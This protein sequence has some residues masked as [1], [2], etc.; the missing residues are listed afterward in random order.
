MPAPQPLTRAMRAVQYIL[1]PIAAPAWIA[2]RIYRRATRTDWEFKTFWSGTI[3][4]LGIFLAGSVLVLSHSPF[5]RIIG[6]YML[7][8]MELLAL[9]IAAAV[10]VGS[11]AGY[12]ALLREVARRQQKHDDPHSPSITAGSI[13]SSVLCYG[14]TIYFLGALAY[15][16]ETGGLARFAG[17]IDRV[18]IDS[19]IDFVYSSFVWMVTLGFGDVTPITLGAKVICAC[20]FAVGLLFNILIFSLFVARLS[21]L[22]QPRDNS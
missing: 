7:F 1:Y 15:L 4:I 6:L 10:P 5:L 2:E 13:Y 11:R 16:F 17:S 8:A 22:H 19:L 20:A 12:K 9:A 3:Y 21:D 18:G 14:F